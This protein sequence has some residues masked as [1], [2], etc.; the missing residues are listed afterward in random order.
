MRYCDFVNVFQGS[1]EIDLPKPEGIAAKWFFIKAG[2]GNT[3]PAAIVPF[4]AMSVSPYSGGYPTGYG[5]HYP[6]SFSRP[7]HFEEGKKLYGFAHIQQSGTGAIGYYYNYLLVTPRYPS[8]PLLREPADEKAAPGYYACT[9]EDI[10]CELTC[11]SRVALHQ[12]TFGH[13]GGYAEIDLSHN[14]LHYPGLAPARCEVLSL[15]KTD[16]DTA[17]VTLRH[18]GIDLYFAL[19]AK[20]LSVKDE[21][22]LLCPAGEE[23]VLSLKVAVS[24]RSG[25]KALGFLGETGSFEET[26]KAAEEKWETALSK[27]EIETKDEKIR[28]I[29]YSNLYHSLIKPADW[30]GES[31]IYPGDGP[32]YTD[33]ATLW[34][35]YKTALPLIFLLCRKEGEEIAES[36]L[37]TGEALGEL[38]N[39][40]GL[41]DEYLLHSQQARMLGA[42]ALL[43][44]YRYGVKLDAE[45]MLRVIESDMFADNK[46]DFTV[47]GRT[48]SHTWM[49][50]MAD[51]A[52]LTAAV[53][54]ERGE[55]ALAEKLEP[56]AAQWKKVS[57]PATGLL[58][59]DSNYYEGTLYNYSFRQMVKMDERMAL[60]GGKEGFVSL[61]DRFFGYG[62][63]DT[64]Q[65][66]DPVNEDPVREGMKLGRFEGFNHE[67]DTEAPFSYVYA[68]RH[69]RTCE[70]VRAGMRY[71]FTTG[72]GGIPGNNDSGALSSYYVFMA[73]GLFPVAG[74]KTFILGSPFVD[75]ARLRLASGKTL[76]ITVE[77]NAPENIYVKS[78]TFNG[79]GIKDFFLSAEEITSG[80]SLHFVMSREK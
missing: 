37:K 20:G 40:I 6:N 49:L 56:L 11:S 34:D 22:T 75:H 18:D 78:V 14:D 24:L 60:A 3:S 72:R 68:G 39:S 26:R 48:G 10:T 31:F 73:V 61:L 32:F 79:R 62:A 27:I 53:A 2:C 1:G 25:E 19:R 76:E 59:A 65:P 16:G 55:D 45:R 43:T 21:K 36:L 67:S 52:A 8:S 47:E 9:L 77:N 71:M 41:N 30:A 42:Y 74:Q 29:F 50:D 15:R 28:E 70:V 51:C 5:D 13:E 63:P 38:P 4:G 46:K 23:G 58:K 69:D 12:Y 64:V 66:T 17:A 35:M 54:R 7:R 57:D 44:A 80:G 33:F